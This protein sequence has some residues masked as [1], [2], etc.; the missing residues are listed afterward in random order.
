MPP[1]SGMGK[2]HASSEPWERGACVVGPY[3]LLPVW[4]PYHRYPKHDKPTKK[5]HWRVHV[6]MCCVR[7]VRAKRPSA[8]EPPYGTRSCKVYAWALKGFLHHGAYVD[9]IWR[10]LDPLA[11]GNLKTDLVE[12]GAKVCRAQAFVGCRLDHVR[13]QSSLQKEAP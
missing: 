11:F 7:T 5:L 1:F 4:V 12:I 6:C 2:P 9:T 3:R 8:W 13:V 10:Y